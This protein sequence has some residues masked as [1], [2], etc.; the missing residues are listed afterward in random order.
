MHSGRCENVEDGHKAKSIFFRAP[1]CHR[2][3]SKLA[4]VAVG[5]IWT[6]Y[7]PSPPP[8]PPLPSPPP[9]SPPLPSPP[10]PS[11]PSSSGATTFAIGIS[12]AFGVAILVST[13]LGVH[14]LKTRQPKVV[15]ASSR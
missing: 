14:F 8:S 12:A 2:E 4:A 1:V 10:S 7:P 6:A 15:D 9:P 13:I 11:L 3:C 5:N